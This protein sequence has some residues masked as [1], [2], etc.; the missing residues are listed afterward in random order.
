[1]MPLNDTGKIFIEIGIL[2]VMVGILVIL[3]GKFSFLG[4]LPGDLVIQTE[5]ISCFIPIVSSLVISLLL[6]IVLNILLRMINK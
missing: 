6:T 1:M 2:L 4:K 3:A 5:N